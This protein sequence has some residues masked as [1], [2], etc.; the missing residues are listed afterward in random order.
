MT[1]YSRPA[2][3]AKSD[4]ASWAAVSGRRADTAAARRRPG[5]ARPP[6]G[7]PS[8]T[9]ASPALSPMSPTQTALRRPGRAPPRRP[10]VG[11]EVGDADRPAG[12]RARPRRARALSPG[13]VG[14]DPSSS[15]GRPARS[16]RRSGV[17]ERN[18]PGVGRTARGRT[19]PRTASRLTAARDDA[20]LHCGSPRSSSS[21]SCGCRCHVDTSS[22]YSARSCSRGMSRC[23]PH[24]TTCCAGCA[25]CP[26][27]STTS[28]R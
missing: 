20:P 4:S 11:P 5:P 25:R 12:R 2:R 17:A 8:P 27:N 22:S 6:P 16:T 28:T 10:R 18:G 1:T 23:A 3:S 19:G 13:V 9:C 21:A 14:G 15:P 7:R 26:T 24:A